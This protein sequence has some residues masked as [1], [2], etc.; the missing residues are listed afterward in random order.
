MCFIRTEQ[1][2]KM[3]I[4]DCWQQPER[5]PDFFSSWGFSGSR[6]LCCPPGPQVSSLQIYFTGSVMCLL[7]HR[8]SASQVQDFSFPCVEFNE[9][10]VG[11]FQACLGLCEW[12]HNSL[13]SLFIK[14]ISLFRSLEFRV[15]ISET[16]LFS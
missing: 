13:V 1:R 6:S 8:D 4:L 15:G 3:T 14:L 16:L 7:V 9:I 5:L 12:Q 11:P 2:R 10:S